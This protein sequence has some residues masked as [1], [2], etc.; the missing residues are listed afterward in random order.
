MPLVALT[1]AEECLLHHNRNPDL[2]RSEIEGW[3][4]SM[5]GVQA[6][7]SVLVPTWLHACSWLCLPC[8]SCRHKQRP[9]APASPQTIIWLPKGLYGDDDTN[10]HI[11]NFACFAAPGHVLLAWT[12]DASDPQVRAA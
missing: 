8:P 5:L 10:G 3:L 4:R 2:G 12:D 6:S 9:L 11:D 1:F 7:Q